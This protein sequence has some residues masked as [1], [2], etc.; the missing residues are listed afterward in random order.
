M[1][2]EI[3][4]IRDW[5]RDFIFLFGTLALIVRELLERYFLFSRTKILIPTN[6]FFVTYDVVREIYVLL[7][8]LQITGNV[9]L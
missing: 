9:K 7:W 4:N 5:N 2:D 3:E 6:L 8:N 1:Q